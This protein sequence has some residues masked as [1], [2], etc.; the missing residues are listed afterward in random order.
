VK[1]RLFRVLGL[2]GRWR[3]EVWMGR[4]ARRGETCEVMDWKARLQNGTHSLLDVAASVAL[5]NITPQFV[6][7]ERPVGDYKG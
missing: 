3:C 5:V 7:V 4:E 2:D 6:Q 1:T